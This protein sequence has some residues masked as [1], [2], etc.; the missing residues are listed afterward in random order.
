MS[1]SVWSQTWQP[2]RLPWPWDSPGKNTGVGCH[3]L[4][5]CMKVKSENEVAQSCPSLRDPMDC[6]L[7]GSFAHGIFQAGV[8]EWVAVAFSSFHLKD[9]MGVSAKNERITIYLHCQWIHWTNNPRAPFPKRFVNNK[10]WYVEFLCLY[11]SVK[12]FRTWMRKRRAL[13]LV[14]QNL[15]P[16]KGAALSDFHI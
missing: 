5:Q 14:S 6:S 8:L 10:T 2:T 3:F 16:R 4:L 15:D 12:W 11:L 7:P 9:F 13:L 1:D